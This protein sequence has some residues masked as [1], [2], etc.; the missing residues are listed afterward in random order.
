VK[1]FFLL[2]AFLTS[3]FASAQWYPDKEASA[4]M[5]AV[6]ESKEKK[7]VL[8]DMDTVY[9]SGV[10]YCIIVEMSNGFLQ[11]HNYSVRS[12]Q[13]QELIYVTY[14]IYY[15]ESYPDWFQVTKHQGVTTDEYSTIEY[16][17]WSFADN[18]KVESPADKKVYK[19]VVEN[20][21]IQGNDLNDEEETK[22]IALNAITFS[23]DREGT[24]LSRLLNTKRTSGISIAGDS[25]MQ[26]KVLIGKVK[27]VQG[28]EYGAA[29]RIMM[30][31]LP[32]GTMIAEGKSYGSNSVKWML[33][34]KKDNQMRIITV[35]ANDGIL[36]VVKYLINGNYL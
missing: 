27:I 17:T 18:Q 29:I 19:M 7:S 6:Q 15:T 21:L 2:L 33:V 10:P 26:D 22:F 12:L 23:Q 31:Y 1:A 3:A 11:P 13:N 30:I 5:K 35:S 34:T 24:D 28:N 25:V 9:A 4:H 8:W 36:D 20:N 14:Q 16:Y 32:D